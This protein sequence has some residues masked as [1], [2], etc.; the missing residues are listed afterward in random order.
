MFFV[1]CFVLFCFVL[2]KQHGCVEF[3]STM[4]VCRYITAERGVPVDEGVSSGALLGEYANLKARAKSQQS[5]PQKHLLPFTVDEKFEAFFHR[6]VRKEATRRNLRAIFKKASSADL[7]SIKEDAESTMKT[8]K[9]RGDEVVD[10]STSKS[11][12]DGGDDG[13]SGGMCMSEFILAYR[14]HGTMRDGLDDKSLAKLFTDAIS[15]SSASA[16]KSG[17]EVGVDGRMTEEEFTKIAEMSEVDVLRTLSRTTRNV[18]GLV[19]VEPSR[20]K[21]FFGETMRRRRPDLDGYDLIVSQ[22]MSMQLYERRVASLQRFVAMCVIFHTMVGHGIY[23]PGAA[24]GGGG[25]HGPVH[26]FTKTL[27]IAITYTIH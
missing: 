23:H 15:S 12:S 25:G 8:K 21:E 19:N 18:G 2:Q 6:P 10:A 1:F 16:V 3:V 11:T 5:G 17:G 4:Y 9:K 20:E 14:Q 13:R 7:G 24:G 22:N 26:V 27:L